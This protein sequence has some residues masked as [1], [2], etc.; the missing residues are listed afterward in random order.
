MLIKKEDADMSQNA[1]SGVKKERSPLKK[2]RFVV[3]SSKEEK[4]KIRKKRLAEALR[5][6]LRKRKDQ[7]RERMSPTSP[8]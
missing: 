5:A 1:E 7:I 3:L 2:P 4:E 8:E 6:N